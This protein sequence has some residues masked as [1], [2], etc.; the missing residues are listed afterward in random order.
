VEQSIR[1]QRGVE[2]AIIALPEVELMFSKTGTAEV[3]TDPMPPNISDGFIILR[4]QDE[5]PEGVDTKEDVI[6]RV[7]AASNA[8]VGQGYELSQPIELRFNELIAGVRGDVA[9]K[10]YGDDLDR[11]TATANLIAPS[12]TPPRGGGR[13]GRT[14]RRRPGLTSLDRRHRALWP[15]REEVAD[16]GRRH[17]RA[18]GRSLF[19]GDRRFDVCRVPG[20]LARPR[21]LGAIPSCCRNRG[22]TAPPCRCGRW[23]PSATP[24]G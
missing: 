4:P 19:E 8:L 18:R 16:G 10:I 11:L 14:D 9:I 2:N 13:Q 20:E 21:R 12:S 3:A 17:G 5:W 24:K 6:E 1:M 15:D 22:C 7:E 23:R